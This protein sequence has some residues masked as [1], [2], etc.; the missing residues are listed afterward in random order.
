MKILRTIAELRPSL[1]AVPPTSTIGLVPTMGAFHGGHVALFHA[2]RHECDP[3][4]ASLFVNPTQ[5]GDPGDLAICP[6][7]EARD[8][9]I[10]EETGVDVLFAP[11]VEEIFPAG[12]GTWITVEGPAQGLE[13]DVRP[14][15]FRGSRPSARSSSRS[16]PTDRLFRAKGRA[17]GC[18]RAADD[19]RPQPSGHHSR[20]T[21]RSGRG[22]ARALITECPSDG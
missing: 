22:R 2:A 14:G 8:A 5:F 11:S 12:S 9:R 15:H 19:A 21:D 6:R 1:R 20:G 16:S 17:A 7:D 18:R 3:V 4:V 10:A 13:A